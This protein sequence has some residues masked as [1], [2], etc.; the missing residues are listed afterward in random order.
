MSRACLVDLTLCMGC[1]GCQVACKQWNGLDAERTG[2]HVPGG[3]Q[4]PPTVSHATHTVVLFHEIEDPGLRWIF[5]KRQC[6]HC[7]EPACA[8][9]CPV[10]AFSTTA[11]GTVVYDRRRCMGC[12]Y[13]MMAC[14]FGVPTYEWHSPVPHVQKCT[15]CDDRPEPICAKT[16]PTGAIEHG[17]RDELLSG[18]R[19]RI[20]GDPSRYHP[21][22]YGE[23]EVGGTRWLYLSPVAFESL[24]FPTLGTAAHVSYTAPA[25]STVPPLVVAGSAALTGLAWIIRRRDEA[26]R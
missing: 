17:S 12:R 3:Y 11:R 8:A 19:S 6:M 1:R 2:F 5:T 21:R 26:K 22:I 18:A 24:G 15:F 14:P 16:C 23:R 20:E 4:N 13:C 25:L 9:A 10:G 7:L